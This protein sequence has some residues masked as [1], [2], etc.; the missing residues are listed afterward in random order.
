[1]RAQNKGDSNV[2]TRSLSSLAGALFAMAAAAVLS[3]CGGGGASGD[4]GNLGGAIQ[5]SPAVGTVYAGVPFNFQITGGRKPYSLTSSEPGL[6][7]VPS[8]IDSNSLDVVAANP[9]VIDTGLAPGDLPVRTVNITVR[10]G[11]GQGTSAVMKVAQNFL[12]GYGVVFTPITCPIANTNDAQACAG[13]ESAVRFSAVFNG[14]LHGN[15]QFRLDVIKGPF[16]FVFPQGGTGGSVVVQSDHTG[17]VNAIIQSTA[18]VRTQLA[19]LRVTEV[20]TGV[21]ADFVFTITG[22]SNNGVLTAIPSSITFTGNLTTDCGIGSSSFFVFDG[23]PPF[24]ALSSDPNITV[25]STSNSNPGS[26][27]VNVSGNSPPCHS[28]TVIVTDSG[29]ARASVDVK[30]VVGSGAA[31]TPPTF[32]VAPTSITLGC[33]ESGS[34]SAVGGSG[35]YSTTSTS[36]QVTAVVSGNTVTITRAGPAGTGLGTMT[37]TVAVTDGA[38]IKTVD[39][40]SPATCP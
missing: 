14:N 3:S 10:S 33:A 5:I 23:S 9:G 2:K 15:Q 37:S 28:G 32:A 29:G 34:V 24:T 18:G 36:S 16:Q 4:T 13:G 27:T 31:P 12:T 38:A 6:L 21:N 11:D 20:A 30:S 8:S 25:N 35:S 40:T 26:F 17:E 39:V 7:P 22:T 1:M 19:V